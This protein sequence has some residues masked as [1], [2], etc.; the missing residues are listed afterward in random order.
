MQWYSIISLK[1]YEVASMKTIFT[2][3]AVLILLALTIIEAQA[4]PTKRLDPGSQ[5]CRTFTSAT[6][7]E[8]REIFVNSCKTCHTRDN[9]KNAPFLHTESKTMNGWNRVFLQKYPEC[10]KNGSWGNLDEEQIARLNDYLYRNAADSWDP[11]ALSC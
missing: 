4:I 10:A 3:L 6:L 2:P 11:N 1:S 8:G 5:T 9:D 7:W